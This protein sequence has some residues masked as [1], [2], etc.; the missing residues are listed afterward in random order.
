[1]LFNSYEFIFIFLPITFIVYFYLM[2]QRL[3]LAAKIF[4]V[5]ASLFF[6]GYWNY[7][8]VPLILLSIF[9]NYGVGV[10]LVNSEQIKRIKGIKKL[11]SKTILTF[12]IVFNLGLLGYFKYTDFFLEN[13]NGIFGTNIP[14]P[15]I[16][17]PIGISFFTF[18][19]IAF[20]VDA[21]RKEAKEYNIFNYMLFVTYFP[22]LLAGPILHHKEMMPQFASKYNYIKNYRNIALGLFIFSI[23][24]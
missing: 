4:L 12:G 16:I 17:L 14:L 7:I 13:F 23:G 9:V 2:N 21:Y 18:T 3:V 1:M 5:I 6:Y 8:Y 11:S 24:L 22:H 19:Q 10:S 20:L 15:H